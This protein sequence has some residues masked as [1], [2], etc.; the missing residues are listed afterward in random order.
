[1]TEHDYLAKAIELAK[2]S[3]AAGGFPAGAVVVKDGKIM[4]TGISIG[5]L[6]H[7]PTSHGE[8]AAIQDACANLETS[9]LSGSTLYG[10]LEPCS[11]CLS[12]AMWAGLARVVFA[13]RKSMVSADYYGGTSES[14][15][16]NMT[17]IRPL[18][19]TH[20]PEQEEAALLLVTEWE[21]TR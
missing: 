20:L 12:A 8:I 17:F 21:T 4:G 7:D 13:G 9:D 16:L 11:M 5:N 2:E 18:E 6:I 1:M 15:S 19:L 3:I 10:S 14:Q